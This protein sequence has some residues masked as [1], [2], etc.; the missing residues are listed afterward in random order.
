[1]LPFRKWEDEIVALLRDTFHLFQSQWLVNWGNETSDWLGT[2][3]TPVTSIYYQL[4]LA[5]QNQGWEEVGEE[6]AFYTS[7]LGF[8]QVRFESAPMLIEMKNTESGWSG[9]LSH[10]STNR[11]KLDGELSPWGQERMA[12]LIGSLLQICQALNLSGEKLQA[13]N[14]QSDQLSRIS[15]PLF[16]KPMMRLGLWRSWRRR[17]DFI[18]KQILARLC[19]WTRL[20]SAAVPVNNGGVC[21]D[22]SG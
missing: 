18:S 4:V 11:G 1:M 14:Q 20:N 3:Q 19:H 6:P 8:R 17:P 16:A 15:A 12:L 21:G 22:E 2:T 13:G 5:V 9:Q 7:L 10:F